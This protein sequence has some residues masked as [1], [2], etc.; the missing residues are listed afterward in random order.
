M[1]KIVNGERVELSKEEEENLKAE[2]EKNRLE[3]LQQKA[4]EQE[5]LAAKQEAIRKIQATAGLNN[6]EIKLLFR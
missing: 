4:K 1:H 3:Q 5:K 2:W 6:D